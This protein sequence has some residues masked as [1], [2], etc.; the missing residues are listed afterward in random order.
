MRC[1]WTPRRA[2]RLRQWIGEIL[3]KRVIRECQER[4]LSAVTLDVLAENSVAIR[5]YE[6]YGFK[7]ES[8][9]QGYAY[10][11]EA[12]QCLRMVLRFSRDIANA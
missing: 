5:L 8:V 7:Q 10:H 11:M 9:E 2:S 4:G 6:N 12:P 1:W 3:L